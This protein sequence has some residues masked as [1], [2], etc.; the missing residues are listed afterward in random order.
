MARKQIIIDGVTYDLGAEAQNVDYTNE[1]MEG[2]TNAEGALDN[3]NER[4]GNIENPAEPIVAEY[5]EAS[6]TVIGKKISV[7]G[8]EED[9][10]G[11]KCSPFI[12][13]PKG[14]RMY[15]KTD[16]A[17]TG[18]LSIVFYKYQGNNTNA[19]AR[20][21]T[22]G[23][24]YSDWTEI[25]LPDN[26]RYLRFTINN[27]SSNHIAIKFVSIP[28]I[29]EVVKLK[30]ASWN[31]EGWQEA[32][33]QMTLDERR[34]AFRE[35][36]DSVNA[37]IICFSEFD[38]WFDGSVHALSASDAVLGNY[39][40]KKIGK[41]ND[42]YNHN[43]IVS[44]LQIVDSREF[45][46]STLTNGGTIKHGRYWK[47]ATIRINGKEIKVVATHFDYQ[48]EQYDTAAHQAEHYEEQFKQIV[49][50]YANDPYVII[51]ADFNVHAW[52]RNGVHKY[53]RPGESD[54]DEVYTSGG[55]TGYLN[56]QYFVDAGYTLL[57]FDYLTLKNPKDDNVQAEVGAHTA[58][59]IAVKGFAMGKREYVDGTT[60]PDNSET[61]G[62]SD[63]PMVACELV[64]L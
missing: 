51:G 44:K 50:Y 25:A 39:P 63:H 17:F 42:A 20:V 22:T 47:E 2:V 11:Y 56:Y 54:P 40:Y 4:I 35:K 14:V 23:G 36:F 12:A 9:G 60:M 62:L 49:A 57:N 59:N 33:S 21:V 29:P 45:G 48:N 61:K 24:P 7:Q 32:S 64:M 16:Y 28:S 31:V 1:D 43:V 55:G 52:D 10:S 46:Y 5:T 13:T 3:L 15:V 19:V 58:D 26:L 53:I 6:A 37:D 18:T 30:V 27:N 41:A 8:T 38:E 34:K